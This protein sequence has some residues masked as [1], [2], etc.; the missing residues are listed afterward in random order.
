MKKFLW[1]VAVLA[2]SAATTYLIA[3]RADGPA[4]DI[5]R[6][7]SVI[8]A[9]GEL[10]VIVE[11]PAGQI[12]SLDVTLVQDDRELPLYSLASPAAADLQQ[13]TAERVRLMRGIGKDEVPELAPGPARLV[14]R[15]ARPVL[16]GLRTV[17]SETERQITVDLDPPRLAVLSTHHYVNHGGAEFVVYRVTP[18][19]VD[20]G[21]RVGERVYPGYPASGARLADVAIVDPEIKVAFF[22][23]LYDQDQNTPIS[24][25]ARDEAGNTITVPLDHRTFAK[26]FARSRINLTDAFL[27]RVVPPLV[28]DAPDMRA[29]D[30]ELVASFLRVNGELRR[31]NDETIASFAGQTAPEVLWSDAFVQLPNTRVE[32]RFAD[33]RTYYYKGREVDQQVHLGCD[34]ASTAHVPVRAANT[35]T[36]LFAGILGIYGNAVIVDHGMGVQS[37]YGHLSSIAVRPGDRVEKG[38]ELGRS[39]QTGL[40]GGD[41]LHFTMLVAG[42]MV[43]P[44]E[45]WDAHWIEDR[46]RRKLRETG[47]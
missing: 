33:H 28:E 35:G 12:S 15:A 9:D 8:G 26:P 22:A 43:S 45:W 42:H 7:V 6:P 39:G 10:E 37:L 34:L 40:A 4:V 36:V 32:A 17:W 18:P 46:I 23:L 30:G 31:R 47:S 29:P 11:T 20:S 21:V 14:V 13:E 16:R 25:F 27:A 19:E 38:H 44:I 5:V 1:I 41:H 24:V 2:A 3:G